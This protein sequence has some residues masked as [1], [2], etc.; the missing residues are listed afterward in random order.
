VPLPR[1]GADPQLRF[2]GADKATA[3][4]AWPQRQSKRR[5]GLL[6]PS[7]PVGDIGLDFGRSRDQR[8]TALDESRVIGYSPIIGGK[9]LARQGRRS[10]GD[11]G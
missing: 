6:A 10:V 1:E 11:R 3:G 2:V 5:R 9:P 7:N 4:L 8:R